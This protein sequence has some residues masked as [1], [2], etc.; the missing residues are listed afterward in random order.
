MVIALPPSAAPLRAHAAA[1]LPAAVVNRV[2]QAAGTTIPVNGYLYDIATARERARALRAALPE[3]AEVFYAVKANGFAPILSALASEL[4]GFEVASLRE[5]E[6][7]QAAATAAGRTARMV[8]AGPGKTAPL[9]AGLVA[10]TAEVVNIES[11]SELYRL[12]EQATRAGAVVPVAVRV[13]P[14]Q[15]PVT[16][17]LTMGGTA[18]AFGVAE[19]DVPQAISLAQRLPGIE[20]AGFHIHAVSNNLDARAHAAY[21]RWCLDYSTRTAAATG[22]ELRVVDI[23]GGLGFDFEGKQVFDLEL[24]GA[25][26]SRIRPPDGVRVILEPGRWLVADCGYYAAE[27]TDIKRTH[28]TWFVVLRGGINHFQLP[29]SWDIIHNFAVVPVDEWPHDWPRQHAA[30]VPVTVVGELCTPEDTL[31]RDV[32]IDVVR[33]GDV[34]VFPNAGSYGW[35]FAMHEFLGHPP[36]PRLTLE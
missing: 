12:S 27:V 15:V 29:T 16:G 6:A 9:L 11:V 23:G 20:V 18:T 3:W 22:V 19:D 4:D 17:S 35:E 5:I 31:A 1:D 34:V 14:A 2:R 13:N 21:L 30:D 32:G 7:A 25:E 28:G 10:G 33:V 8:A 26:L 36:A 24:F